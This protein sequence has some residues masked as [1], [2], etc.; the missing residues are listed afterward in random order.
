MKIHTHTRE[1]AVGWLNSKGHL[2]YAHTLRRHRYA[3]ADKYPLTYSDPEVAYGIIVVRVA[4]TKTKDHH[5][6]VISE[7]AASMSG[8]CTIITM[9]L[10]NYQGKE[11]T[12]GGKN[13]LSSSLSAFAFP[14]LRNRCL[15]RFGNW[16]TKYFNAFPLRHASFIPAI[17]AQGITIHRQVYVSLNTPNLT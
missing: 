3:F 8:Y 13:F 7:T 4:S 10:V 16:I 11:P 6:I 2:V 5:R 17:S 9:P 12:A 1:L 15:R 14:S